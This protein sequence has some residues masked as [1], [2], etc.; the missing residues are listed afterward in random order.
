MSNILYSR[1]LEREL[2][3][4]L[5]QFEDWKSNLTDEQI[6]K[7]AKELGCWV[8]DLTEDD[9]RQGWDSSDADRI[10]AIQELENEVH[11]SE[12]KYEI[13]FIKDSYFTEY[14]EQLA[15]DIGAIDRNANWPL[16]HINWEFAAED[17]KNDYS[18]VEFDGETYWYRS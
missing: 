7:L 4:L 11:S 12:W 3:E 2:T 5:E 8:I 17:L 16:N 6:H 9:F 18:S 14:A 10:T 1:D 13:T 15:K